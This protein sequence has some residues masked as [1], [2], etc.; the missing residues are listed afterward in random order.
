MSRHTALS[1]LLFAFVILGTSSSGHSQ[2]AQA[3]QPAASSDPEPGLTLASAERVY[4]AAEL[5]TTVPAGSGR[6]SPSAERARE[7]LEKAMTKWGRFTL[8]D[9]PEKADLILVIVEGSRNSGVRVGLLTER[10]LIARGGSDRTAFL[11]KSNS[12]DGGIRDYRP[13]ARTVDEFRA[14]VEEYDKKLPTELVAQTRAARRSDASSGGCAAAQSDFPDCIAHGNSRLYLP[15][16]REENHGAVKLSEVVLHMSL[17][18]VGK[19]VSVTEFSNYIVA[20][21]KLLN[22][23]FTEAQRQPG[24]DIAVEGTLQPDGKADFRLASRP[25]V[26]Q[27]QLQSFYDGLLR[28]PRP[29]IHDGPVE[30]RAVF[31]LW[32]GSEE[33][34][35]K[36]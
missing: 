2:E 32:G 36:R 19:Y 5:G 20:I 22:Q 26:D 27:Q 4:L 16:D 3:L 25:E 24:K 29:A 23:Q 6:G 34:H 28:L 33:S 12:Y 15:D 8:V 11:W 13:V 1:I 17:L 7:G 14:A 30:F 9:D 31:Q 18:D 35:T 10:L 21:Q